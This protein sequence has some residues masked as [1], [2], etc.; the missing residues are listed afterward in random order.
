[1]D[2]I[3]FRRYEVAPWFERPFQTSRRLG[4]EHGDQ[5]HRR[6]VAIPREQAFVAEVGIEEDDVGRGQSAAGERRCTRDHQADAPQLAF[7]RITVVILPVQQNGAK[8]AEVGDRLTHEPTTRR[9]A[10]SGRATRARRR[11]VLK[12]AR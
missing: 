5:R 1:M 8:A 12:L 3:G 11:S 6:L 10:R 2:P 4:G 7:Q 9:R